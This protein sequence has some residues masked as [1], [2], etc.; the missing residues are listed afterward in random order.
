MSEASMWHLVCGPLRGRG[1]ELRESKYGQRRLRRSQGQTT[2]QARPV[3][4]MDGAG[5]GPE[6]LRWELL[7]LN[8][9]GGQRESTWPRGEPVG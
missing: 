9:A 6:T 3:S 8:G 2:G 7:L 1:P 4:S 5:R